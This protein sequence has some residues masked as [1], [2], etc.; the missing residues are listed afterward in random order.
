MYRIKKAL[1]IFLA[2]WLLVLPFATTNPAKADPAAT[3]PLPQN[4]AHHLV[5]NDGTTIIDTYGSPAKTRTLTLKGYGSNYGKQKQFDLAD[6]ITQ[7][8]YLYSIDG[9][10]YT[11]S[12]YYLAVGSD[13]LTITTVVWYDRPNKLFK[14]F[15]SGPK[16]T[17]TDADSYLKSLDANTERTIANMT[18]ETVPK[19][20]STIDCPGNKLSINSINYTADGLDLTTLKGHFTKSSDEDKVLGTTPK[21]PDD[22]YLKV[23][24]KP[25][26][27]PDYLISG[28]NAPIA[29]I[30]ATNGVFDLS[31]DPD[32]VA[33]NIRK[34]TYSF[35]VSWALE[36]SGTAAA[37]K[38]S[39]NNLAG[40]LD[41]GG[42]LSSLAWADPF[43]ATTASQAIGALLVGSTP[44]ADMSLAYYNS[45]RDYYLFG[46]SKE[47]TITGDQTIACSSLGIDAKFQ[48][49][50]RR[51]GPGGDTTG[52]GAINTNTIMEWAFCEML[53]ALKALA[54][55][56][57][58][59]SNG[60]FLEMTN[61]GSLQS[62]NGVP[63]TS[64]PTTAE[65][66][67]TG[68]TTTTTASTTATTTGGAGTSTDGSETGDGLRHFIKKA[69][70]LGSHYTAFHN[71]SATTSSFTAQITPTGG[72]S[73]SA[74]AKFSNWDGTKLTAD[75]D[76]STNIPTP[77]AATSYSASIVYQGDVFVYTN[78]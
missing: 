9:I 16:L 15:F 6:G 12:E 51:G 23:W 17:D 14:D 37:P 45:N 31:Q 33:P 13:S 38:W 78:P 50:E 30:K 64:C 22:V 57:K 62:S 66:G 18:F 63:L 56:A 53:Y 35:S 71:A 21:P 49:K 59:K 29:K 7:G 70:P 36:N 52:C 2:T 76:L 5:A 67:G 27:A 41:L 48:S 65:S 74:T 69:V 54:T 58:C 10:T 24:Y 46:G 43:S 61:L 75:I 42:L 34:G 1:L 3:L 73:Y 68:S 4:T 28:V 39:L 72:T 19:T 55:W 8:Q 77:I 26:G 20:S 44:L 60:I 25:P 40:G 11:T 32:L 47:V